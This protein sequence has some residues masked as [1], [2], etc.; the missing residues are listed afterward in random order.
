MEVL[1]ARHPTSRFGILTNQLGHDLHVGLKA[2]LL[3]VL[4]C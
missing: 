3:E 4:T 2:Q 1:E